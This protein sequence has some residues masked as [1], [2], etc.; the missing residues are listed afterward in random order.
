MAYLPK[1][2]YS[3]K[4][5]PGGELLYKSNKEIYIGDYMSLSTGKY[6]AGTNNIQL[7]EE[8][9]IT[10]INAEEVELHEP[11]S[12]DVVRHKILKENIDIFLKETNPIPEENPLPTDKE[13]DRGYY[14]RYFAKRINNEIYIEIG[15]KTYKDI[16]S[17]KPKYDHNLYEVGDI[18]WHLTGNVF[19]KNTTSIRQTQKIFRYINYH[20]IKLDEHKLEEELLQTHLKTNGGELYLASGK[21]YIGEYHINDGGPMV[22]PTHTEEDHPKLYYVSKLPIPPDTTYEDFLSK[23]LPKNGPKKQVKKQVK[24][25]N[26]SKFKFKSKSNKNIKK[27]ISKPVKRASTSTKRSGY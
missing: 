10:S 15:S 4:N 22:G 8:L 27:L 16:K 20:F 25:T 9:I 11:S 21:D 26:K 2:K 14:K 12:I 23:T 7:G 24:K 6:Y 3:I 17:K 18:T 13:Y 5:T 19:L 1:S